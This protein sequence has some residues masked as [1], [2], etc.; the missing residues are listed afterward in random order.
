MKGINYDETFAPVTKLTSLHI[1]LALTA[2][3]DL[4]V[5]QMDIKLAYLKRELKEEIYMKPPPG[6]YTL[7]GMVFQLVKVVYG[8]K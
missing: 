7:D 6:F 8:T 3:H 4:E 1:I 2:E 5:H